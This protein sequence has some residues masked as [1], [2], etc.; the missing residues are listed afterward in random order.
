[1]NPIRHSQPWAVILVMFL[2]FFAFSQEWSDLVDRAEKQLEQGFHQTALE[3]AE[4]ALAMLDAIEE[5][6]DTTYANV[7]YMVGKIHYYLGN[8]SEA[9]SYWRTTLDIRQSVHGLYHAQVARLLNNLAILYKAQG[10]YTE[11]EPLYLDAI[12]IREHVNGPDHPEVAICFNNLANLYLSQA[13]YSEAETLY[14]KALKIMEGVY[15]ED[16]PE[17]ATSLNNLAALYHVQGRYAAEEPLYLRSLEIWETAY[18]SDHHLV[19]QSLNNLA[20]LYHDLGRDDEAEHLYKRALS[21]RETILRPNHPKVGITLNNLARLFREQERYD[22]AEPLVLR[23]LSIAEK[24]LGLTHPD[25]AEILRNL[26]DLRILQN[27]LSEAQ[28]ALERAMNIFEDAMGVDHPYVAGTLHSLALISVKKRDWNEARKYQ[29]QAYKIRFKN[30]QEGFAVL[31]ER[32]ALEYSKFLQSE[33]ANYLSILLDSDDSNT[34]TDEKIAEVVFSI[35]GQVTDGIFNRHRAINSMIEMTDSLRMIRSALSDLYVIGENENNSEFFDKKSELLTHRKEMLE[36]ELARGVSG[37]ADKQLAL[38]ISARKIGGRLQKGSSVVEFMKYEHRVAPNKTE[39]RY[40]AITL[41]KYSSPRAYTLGTASKIDSLVSAYRLHFQNPRELDLDEYTEIC[42]NLY[43]LL[44]SPVISDLDSSE[45]VLIAPDGVLNLISFGGLLDRSG[46]YLIEQF[47][48]HYLSSARD[49]IYLREPSRYG[50]GLLS[51]GDPDY[52]A[53]AEEE[54]IFEQIGSKVKRFSLQGFGRNARTGCEALNKIT[55]NRLPRTR[56]EVLQVSDKWKTVTK[57]P[58]SVYLDKDA[59]EEV[60]KSEASGKRMIHLATHGYFIDAECKSERGVREYVH[61]N[62]LL[63]SGIFLAGSNLKKGMNGGKSKEDGIVTAEEVVGI[64][65]SG[66]QLVVLSA[67]ESGLGEIRTGEGV[68]GLRRAFQMAGARSVI[69]TLWQVDDKSTADL[70]G[71]LY[72]TNESLPLTLQRIQ[73]E[74][75]EAHRNNTL[76]QH[77]FFWAGFIVTG[78]WK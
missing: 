61:E 69:S 36:S 40:L 20:Y 14:M 56:D 11:S 22:E 21:I 41:S 13:R 10:R 50:N 24:E 65:L 74:Q 7:V 8:Y 49:V 63:L 68:Y 3:T 2:P 29:S 55:V 53:V 66:V 42:N 75:I 25:V 6:H 59:T 16:D 12:E 1:M 19:A 52:D 33:S 73:I 54:G 34:D 30:F 23:A 62:P 58:V 5:S 43:D 64:N 17:V 27:R 47:P 70:I 4:N 57:E 15:G 18:G 48:I 71:S 28:P 44:V 35:K 26:G 46:R 31:S 32:N 9:E 78:A 37:F 51:M 39:P 67:C 60:L 76:K 72:T 45:L 38:N 77:P